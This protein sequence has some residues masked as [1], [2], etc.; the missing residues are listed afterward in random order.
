MFSERINRLAG[1][2]IRD[3]LAASQKSDMIS[4][5]GGLP[6]ADCLP[7]MDFGQTP[8]YLAQYGPTEG[9]PELREAI[10]KHANQNLG[11][12]CSANQVLILA[13]SQQ[14]LDLAT[15][16]FVDKGTP[17]IT[18]APTFLAALQIL[19]LFGAKLTEIEQENGGLNAQ[20]LSQLIQSAKPRMA[21]LIPSFQNPSGACYSEENRKEIAEVFNQ[22]KMP[23][24]EDDPYRDLSYDGAAPKP[25]TSYLKDAPFI[26]AG[27]FSKVLAPGLRVGYLIA[28]PDLYP[29]LVKLKQASD[30]HVNRPAQ[31]YV[32]EKITHPDFPQ[33]IAKLQ[34]SYKI[35]RDTMQTALE[36]NFGD[37]ATWEKP[38]GGLFFWIKLNKAIDTR[39]LLAESM[40]HNVA[41][42]PGEPFFANPDEHLGFIRLNFSHANAEKINRGM[43]ILADLVRKKT[44]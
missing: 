28:S 31:W 18:E 7:K 34:A 37:L 35:G 17:I 21:Y 13:G 39:K 42:M 25:I 32:M 9:E 44:A 27:S 36:T 22:S 16:L 1:S 6:A 3:I 40:E 14:A 2:L 19:N 10:A 29:F 43:K 11:I 8:D 24:F 38:K 5:A 20:K 33:H 30:L 12:P 26:Y 23:L 15:K 41:F 4:F